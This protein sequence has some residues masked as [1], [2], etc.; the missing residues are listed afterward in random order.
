MSGRVAPVAFDVV[1]AG[2][3]LSGL[4]AA[5]HS[6]RSGARVLLVEGKPDPTTFKCAEGVLAGQLE[7]CGLPASREWV[8][9]E[10]TRFRLRSPGGLT[11]EPRMRYN[12]L[13][14]LDRARFQSRLWGLAQDSGCEL[15]PGVRAGRLDLERG[16]LELGTGGTVSGTVFID[17]T[18]TGAFLGRQC[19]IPRLGRDGLTVLAQ[20]RME[21]RGPEEDMFQFLFGRRHRAPAGYGWIFPKGN[22]VFNIGVCGVASH[23]LGTGRP[24]DLLESFIRGNVPGA[25]RRLGLVVSFLPMARPLDRPVLRS[26]DGARS[27]MMVGDSARLCTAMFSAGIANALLSGRWAGEHWAQPERYERTVRERLHGSLCRGFAF[28][29]AHLS[30]EAM[31]RVFRRRL[32]PMVWLHGLLPGLIEGRTMDLL[33]W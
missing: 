13:A 22:G 27:L 25:G 11:L 16:T 28:K 24:R 4:M 7:Q 20:W 21:A 32:R 6:A 23:F 14:I 8:C 33:G 31:E 9:C 12:R 18:G 3:S 29:S 1:I 5:V 30:D 17:A 10:L 15:R 2:G 26:A 19:G